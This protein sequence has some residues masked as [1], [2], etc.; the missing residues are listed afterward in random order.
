MFTHDGVEVVPIAQPF[1]WR[2][3]VQLKMKLLRVNFR[4]GN[5]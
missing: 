3:L 5:L 4:K 2:K 1:I